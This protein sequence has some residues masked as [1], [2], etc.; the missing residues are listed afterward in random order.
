M[1]YAASFPTG[2]PDTPTSP[3]RVG[4]PRDSLAHT[5]LC[6]LWPR[7]YTVNTRPFASAAPWNGSMTHEEQWRVLNESMAY[8]LGLVVDNP[9]PVRLVPQ[10]P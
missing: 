8:F 3:V 2:T 1:R 10:Y 4:V 6:E 7:P 9:Y 5:V